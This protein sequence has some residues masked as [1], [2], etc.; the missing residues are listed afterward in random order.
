MRKIMFISALNDQDKL[1]W[2]NSI[3]YKKESI[4]SKLTELVNFLLNSTVMESEGDNFGKRSITLWK[5]L[6]QSKVD[7][8]DLCDRVT[9]ISFLFWDYLYFNNQ[10]ENFDLQT[11]N[12]TKEVPTLLQELQMTRNQLRERL[13]EIHNRKSNAIV[14]KDSKGNLIPWNCTYIRF[15]N[16]ID[17]FQKFN[18]FMD[19]SRG[20]AYD[21]LKATKTPFTAVLRLSSDPGTLA[22]SVLV[23]KDIITHKVQADFLSPSA[24]FFNLFAEARPNVAPGTYKMARKPLYEVEKEKKLLR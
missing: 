4:H 13:M 16:T 14:K 17:V 7:S 18:L 19:I 5:E 12:A 23:D 10:L 21:R 20:H 24:T 2:F 6:A 15:T 11:L 22:L 9:D 8:P 3:Y 1:T